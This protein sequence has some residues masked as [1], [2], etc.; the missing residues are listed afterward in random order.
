MQL[1]RIYRPGRRFVAP[2]L[3]PTVIFLTAAAFSTAMAAVSSTPVERA[4]A[5]TPP[6]TRTV[7]PTSTPE[8]TPRPA[9]PV[10]DPVTPE[11]VD[12]YD[13]M[14]VGFAEDGQ[15]YIGDPEAPIIL[16]EY[17]D[18]LCPF[19]ERHFQ[20]TYPLLLDEFVATG[21][22]RLVFHDF[23]I[24]SLHPTA[25]IGHQAALCVA[26]Q[27]RALFWA[28]HD[29]LY[30]RQSEW[31]RLGD[32]TAFVGALAGE[33]G[34]DPEA[35]AACME[36]ART[37][38]AVDASIAAGE[39][40]G[41]NG[42]P[43]FHLERAADG[44]TFDIVG[45][46][47]IER[48]R[49]VIDAMLAGEEAPAEPTP[50][51]PKLPYWADEGLAP[52]PE[53]PGFTL[54]GDPYKGSED[55]VL[56]VVEFSDFQCPACATH[57]LEVQPALDEQFVAAG[58]VRW[59]FKNLPLQIHPYAPAAASAA[60]CAGDQGHFWEMH[61]QLF[62]AQDRW[63]TETVDEEMLNLADGLGLELV[64]FKSCFMGRA[65]L[66]R[67]LPDLYDAQGLVSATPTFVIL[68]GQTGTVMSGSRNAEEF[69]TL[70][71]SFLNGETA[72]SQNGG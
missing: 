51:A 57:A 19:C 40:L 58:E 39:A 31:N 9:T 41:F 37:I 38:D 67:V 5:T 6:A 15:A 25:P 71:E 3:L 21:Q 65:S 35:Y 4:R 26:E 68:Q 20:E 13:G 72:S 47:P 11:P 42:T 59:V 69:A 56:T 30:A 60:E 61:D 18:Y 24:P 22:V 44:Y 52:D 23:P 66:E 53:R 63:T 7:A 50:E 28:M 8:P 54:A 62:V 12:E 70:L 36:S 17:S 55:A 64:P 29:A 48:F 16:H 1:N 33:I 32:P 2:F 43:S 49:D 34:A 45:A 27:G 10:T 46:Y 14:P